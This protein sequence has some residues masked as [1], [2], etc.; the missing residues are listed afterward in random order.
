MLWHRLGSALGAE[1]PLPQPAHPEPW[2]PRDFTRCSPRRTHRTPGRSHV[3]S[4]GDT[5]AH[6]G[7]EVSG[8]LLPQNT[9]AWGTGWTQ[10]QERWCETG[11]VPRWGWC[12][13]DH[14]WPSRLGLRD[15]ASGWEPQ[16]AAV[17]EGDRG[18]VQ[19]PSASPASALQCWAGRREGQEGSSKGTLVS[20]EGSPLAVGLIILTVRLRGTLLLPDV[21]GEP[22]VGDDPAVQGIHL[23]TP[24][25]EA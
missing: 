12:L 11:T 1:L 4:M 8:A 20:D 9:P 22:L 17:Q 16:A 19:G 6:A 18:R 23:H 2:Q 7:E 21:R 5:A 15:G 10:G 14:A 24:Q 13:Q 25:A 3:P